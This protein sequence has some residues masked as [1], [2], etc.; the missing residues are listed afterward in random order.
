MDYP[1]SLPLPELRSIVEEYAKVPKFIR[2][3]NRA[4][5]LTVDGKAIF[6]IAGEW[7]YDSTSY[8]R[9]GRI[10]RIYYYNDRVEIPDKSNA[11]VVQLSPT[12]EAISAVAD[13]IYIIL[14]NQEGHLVIHD[15]QN[16]VRSDRLILPIKI[17]TN[18]Q[19]VAP[20]II[21]DGFLIEIKRLLYH[22]RAADNTLRFIPFPI[23]ES[24]TFNWKGDLKTWDRK[25]SRVYRLE[26]DD[27]YHLVLE[28]K[29][30]GVLTN[31]YF[32]YGN[33]IQNL[34]SEEKYAKGDLRLHEYTIAEDLV[35]NTSGK[36]EKLIDLTRWVMGEEAVL[37]E[38]DIRDNYLLL[39]QDKFHIFFR[40]GEKLFQFNI[41]SRVMSLYDVLHEYGDIQAMY[42]Q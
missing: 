28:T 33:T 22:Y 4:S 15:Y 36:T 37:Y 17:D 42:F 20:T 32:I 9:R 2:I 30:M 39:Y 7:S 24:I 18:K 5:T 13:H 19:E 3:D 21:H 23:N 10:D 16:D 40:I 41:I 27:T 25:Q 11:D 31:N 14:V 8:D 6:R 38:G 1:A 35:I 34:K 12:Y 29:E 26:K